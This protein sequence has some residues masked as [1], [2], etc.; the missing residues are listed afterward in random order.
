MNTS[1]HYE[2]KYCPAYNIQ[3][4]EETG[5][6]NFT[7]ASN[8]SSTEDGG[9]CNFGNFNFT[10]C[11]Y[12]NNEYTGS[13]NAMILC[14]SFCTYSNCSFIGNKVNHLFYEK[15]KAI[16]NC[17]FKNNNVTVRTVHHGYSGIFESGDSLD[18]FISHYTTDKCSATYFYKKK[19]SEKKLK[20]K[21]VKNIVHNVFKTS[22]V[23]SVNISSSK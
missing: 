8:T 10:K 17:Y 12:L 2:I 22:F 4:P 13:D 20:M 15:P 19:V 1:Y 11:N 9:I 7:T 18:S 6:I 23:V 16:D 14:Y 3:D 21:D 5:I